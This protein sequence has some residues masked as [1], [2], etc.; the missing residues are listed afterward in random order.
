MESRK[1][2]KSRTHGEATKSSRDVRSSLSPAAIASRPQLKDRG[3]SAPLVPQTSKPKQEK[4]SIHASTSS[5]ASARPKQDVD[6][7][8][9]TP[10]S[11]L[12]PVQIQQE[13]LS[14]DGS[15]SRQVR[16]AVFYCISILV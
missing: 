15:A 11:P 9:L 13:E 16:N 8:P 1:P 7:P 3:K 6:T 4:H 2:K 12:S 14:Q 5:R 10:T